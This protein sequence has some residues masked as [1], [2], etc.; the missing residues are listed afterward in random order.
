MIV[1]EDLNDEA[2]LN[3]MRETDDTG[4]QGASHVKKPPKP[5]DVLDAFYTIR[6]LLAMHDDDVAM[7]RLLCSKK[8]VWVCCMAKANKPS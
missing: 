7:D 4:N 3:S 2:I 5:W 8:D 1:H 6:T